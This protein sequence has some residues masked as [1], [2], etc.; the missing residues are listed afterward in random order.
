MCV[1]GQQPYCKEQTQKSAGANSTATATLLRFALVFL[2]GGL[3]VAQP[4][5]VGEDAR[6]GD[7]ALET[8]KGRFNPFVFADCDLGH[9]RL[10]KRKQSDNLAREGLPHGAVTAPP[11]GGEGQVGLYR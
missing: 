9:E 8:A 10:C 3:V 5:E 1:H 4:L 7:L 11:L 2:G 6:L